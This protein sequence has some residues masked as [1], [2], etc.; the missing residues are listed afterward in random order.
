MQVNYSGNRINYY[1]SLTIYKNHFVIILT[2]NNYSNS[3]ELSILFENLV[4]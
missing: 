3:F 2:R 4:K 1:L